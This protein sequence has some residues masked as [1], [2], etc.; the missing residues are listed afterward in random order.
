MSEPFI[1]EIR[2]FAGN[3]APRGWAFCQ[4]Q[5]LSISTND[6]LFSLIGTTYGGDGRNTFALPELRGRLPIHQGT[7]PGLTP[8]PI[9]QQGGAEQVALDSTHVPQHGHGFQASTAAGS[10]STP[11]SNVV[12]TAPSV[13]AFLQDAPTIG[14]VT[15]TG[16]FGSQP[17]ENRMPAMAI[18]YIIA[19]TGL[20]PS[21]N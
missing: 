3:F 8:R 7:G 2:I 16:S 11:E 20:Y 18:H 4:G 17:H 5:L 9:G 12:A 1:G 6:A 10:S 13:T 14:T 21:R 15:T 19:L